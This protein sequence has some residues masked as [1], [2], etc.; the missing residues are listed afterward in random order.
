MSWILPGDIL[1]QLDMVMKTKRA[2]VS[3]EISALK[4]FHL[5]NFV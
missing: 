3:G 4:M 2:V 1:H 5:T